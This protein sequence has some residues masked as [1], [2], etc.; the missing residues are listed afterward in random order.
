MADR[1]I[2]IGDVHGCIAELEHLLAELQVDARDDLLFLGDLV[3]KGPHSGAV[4]KLARQ[5]GARC[6]LGNHERRLL[7]FRETGDRAMLKSRD[8]RTLRQLTRADWDYLD[9]MPLR[10]ELPEFNTVAVHGGFVPGQHW[11][12]QDAE[13]V[14]RVQ[15]IDATGTPRKRADSPASPSWAKF[16]RG[17]EFVIYGHTPRRDVYRLPCSIG[18]D[19][20]CVYGGRLTAFCFPHRTL[21]QVEA[22]KSYEKS[23]AF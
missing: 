8:A 17:P 9:A 14:T 19:T 11:R 6:V 3:N 4:V 22:A 20:G 18:I 7:R 1:T 13:I 2:I 15:V 12:L 10:I 23:A 21:H 16:W 5:A